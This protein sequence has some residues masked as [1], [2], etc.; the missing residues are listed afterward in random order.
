MSANPIYAELNAL[1]SQM[2]TVINQSQ[3]NSLESC[4]AT[5]QRCL[6]YLDNRD[7][8]WDEN[9]DKATDAIKTAA[10]RVQRQMDDLE[11]G[12]KYAHKS[13]VAEQVAMDWKERVK[14]AGAA[15]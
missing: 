4:K 7:D 10:W 2:Q 14:D 6:D 12:V 9:I 11:D 5:L 1:Q 13:D 3:V 15:R 8:C